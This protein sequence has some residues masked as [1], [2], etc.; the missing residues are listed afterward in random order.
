LRPDRQ[1]EG[2]GREG[3]ELSVST[4]AGSV[5]TC[6]A[7]LA[8]LVTL[9]DAHVLA[10][11]RLHGDD[12]TVPLLATRPRACT[13]CRPGTGSAIR[14]KTPLPPDDQPAVTN[15][16]GLGNSDSPIGRFSA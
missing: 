2:Y 5:G 6:T 7:L 4:L 13:N 1:S 14:P 11:G 12:T 8:L 9:I 15:R 16:G 10:A 3:V